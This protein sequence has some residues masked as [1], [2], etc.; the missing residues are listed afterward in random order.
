METLYLTPKLARG[1]LETYK[2]FETQEV[3]DYHKR[4]SFYK[5]LKALGESVTQLKD[6]SLVSIIRYLQELSGR[7]DLN[8]ATIPVG[9]ERM[10]QEYEAWQEKHA[11]AESNRTP[12]ETAK[13]QISAIKLDREIDRHA[14]KVLYESGK[15]ESSADKNQIDKW[16]LDKNLDRAQKT[17]ANAFQEQGLEPIDADQ[18][19]RDVI[20]HIRNNPEAFQ[21]PLQRLVTD[22]LKQIN[23]DFPEST[24][25]QIAES[26]SPILSQTPDSTKNQAFSL[27]DPLP[28]LKRTT[29][30]SLPDQRGS[31]EKTETPKTRSEKEGEKLLTL[32]TNRTPYWK[33]IAYQAASIFGFSDPT[34]ANNLRLYNI[35]IQR[36]QIEN[37]RFYAEN[38]TAIQEIRN[39]F[40]GIVSSHMRLDGL[41][42]ITPKN[43]I[44]TKEQLDQISES[45]VEVKVN[46]Q[47]GEVYSGGRLIQA[48]GEKSRALESVQNEAASK[49]KD[50]SSY[51][52]IKARESVINIGRGV[53]WFFGGSP[54][55]QST[56]NRTGGGG[57]NFPSIGIGGFGGIGK[58]GA[59]LG[60]L[61]GI[62]NI[63][64][65]AKMGPAGWVMMGVFGVAGGIMLLTYMSITGS[66]GIFQGTSAGI[67][68][69]SKYISLTKTAQPTQFSNDNLPA[70]VKY[71]ITISA[72]EGKL[73]NISF[74]DQFS[75]FSKGTPKTPTS[76]IS[77]FDK[78]PLETGQS[79]TFTYTTR[80]E[81]DIKDSVVTNTFTVSADVAEGPKGETITKTASIIIGSPPTGC[82]NF[83]GSWDE[84][85]KARV[86]ENIGKLSKSTTYI[87]TICSGGAVQIVRGGEACAYDV[88]GKKYCWAG[89]VTGG[90]TINLYNLAFSR[91]PSTLFYTVA[92]ESGHIYGHRNRGAYEVFIKTAPYRTENFIPTYTLGDSPDEDFAETIAV[93][94][95]RRE[96]PNLSGTNISEMADRWPKHYN[97]A[98]DNIF[99]GFDGY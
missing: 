32:L 38:F 25:N 66:Q 40:E 20:S 61:A 45:L 85:D 99:G 55:Q 39:N 15:R 63:T 43:L 10:V 97:F 74:K 46:E 98:K 6:K 44:A 5:F 41:K 65:L 33:T 86:I 2:E 83:I 3:V 96:V 11:L 26:V 28:S 59:S 37:P 69:E 23:P 13:L 82:F 75:V 67:T 76:N 50:V 53:S 47:T 24:V 52:G 27:D 35:A 94:I 80:L 89:E 49:L 70:E 36:L 58:A 88:N 78:A 84:N 68:P 29:Y 62:Q 72:K 9:M 54:A 93:Y 18:K 17:F 22:A 30:S 14:Q 21:N 16:V 64:K 81:A 48:P 95:I 56:E 71:T 12:E 73:E 31:E 60:K 91:G 79:R 34:L 1:L 92:H 90:N 57:I 4:D 42:F 7:D 87:S 77:S 19:A 51:G 8:K